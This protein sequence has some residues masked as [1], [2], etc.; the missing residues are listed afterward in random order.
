MHLDLHFCLLLVGS[1]MLNSASYNP[2]DEGLARWGGG[3]E[4]T[5]ACYSWELGIKCKNGI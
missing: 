1:L 5:R 4:K 3:I 2:Y